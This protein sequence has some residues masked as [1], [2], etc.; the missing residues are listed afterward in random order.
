MSFESVYMI[1]NGSFGTDFGVKVL[2]VVLALVACAYDWRT[3]KRG[4]YAWAMVFGTAVWTVVEVALQSTG[5]REIHRGVI[6]GWELP[7]WFS[8]LLQGASEG[9]V[10]AV[11]GVFC[12]DRI[13]D[14]GKRK[15]GVGVLVAV[16]VAVVLTTANQAAVTRD[17][18]GDVAS[19]RE[20]FTVASVVFLSAVT[21]FVVVWLWKSPL[22]VRSRGIHML[23]TTVVFAT[24][25]TLAEF[26]AKTRWIE[27][28]T[29][30]NFARAPP[31]IEFTTL[32]WD[33]VVEIGVMYVPFLAIP[34][35]LHLTAENGNHGDA[36]GKGETPANVT[37]KGLPRE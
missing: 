34:Q 21:L 10:I 18:G 2:M 13:R 25:W 7:A 37:G 1:R 23:V 5:V 36:S 19:R 33:V 12:G 28:G 17:V 15:V 29:P 26:F 22:P 11:L 16:V 24:A 8:I 4:D 14:P 6:L 27:T 30:G 9:A 3:E 32:S 35:L 31:L 20:V